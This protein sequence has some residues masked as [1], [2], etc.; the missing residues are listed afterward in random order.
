MCAATSSLR[1]GGGRSVSVHVWCFQRK[2]GDGATTGYEP[3]AL[4]AHIRA[5]SP[6]GILARMSAPL[7]AF[8]DEEPRKR[9]RRRRSAPRVRS[10]ILPG[11]GGGRSVS[12]PTL[13]AGGS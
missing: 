2:S 5:T 7:G 1:G 6:T 4:H 9:M 12:V 13:R 8:V 3:C 10:P 11:R